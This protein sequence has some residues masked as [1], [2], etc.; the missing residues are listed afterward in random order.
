[1]VVLLNLSLDSYLTL[2]IATLLSGIKPIVL[3]WTWRRGEMPAPSGPRTGSFKSYS[4]LTSLK[5]PSTPL[6]SWSALSLSLS[7]NLRSVRRIKEH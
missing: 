5:W 6:L 1:M 3:P 4:S 2:C 7:R